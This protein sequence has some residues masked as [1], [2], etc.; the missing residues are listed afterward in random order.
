MFW[1]KERKKLLTFYVPEWG[2]F[3]LFLAKGRAWDLCNPLL[4]IAA[5]AEGRAEREAGMGW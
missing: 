5:L 4:I 2:S 1:G 3:S